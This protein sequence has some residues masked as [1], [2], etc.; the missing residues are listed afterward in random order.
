MSGV[1]GRVPCVLG[2][3]SMHSEENIFLKYV[4]ITFII[5]VSHVIY[6][7]YSIISIKRRSNIRI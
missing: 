5:L 4:V 3:G 6:A 2:S 7:C 1:G